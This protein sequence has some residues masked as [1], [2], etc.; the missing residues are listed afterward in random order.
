VTADAGGATRPARRRRP[1]LLLA[2]AFVAAPAWL[3]WAISRRNGLASPVLTTAILGANVV[4]TWLFPT[5]KARA[6]R[7]AQRSVINPPVRALLFIGVLPLGLALLETTG[8]RSRQPRR[9]PVGDGLMGHTFWIVAE[10]GADAGYVRNIKEDPCVRVQIRRGVRTRW[11]DG[12]A[13]VLEGD[14]PYA[15]QRQ[16]CRRHPLRAVNAAMVRVLGTDLVTVRI[17]LNV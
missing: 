11:Y 2:S 8:R 12:T 10:H 7:L 14:D 1:R 13:T 5:L 17:D 9:T 6:V 4:V 3:P 16:L 15:R